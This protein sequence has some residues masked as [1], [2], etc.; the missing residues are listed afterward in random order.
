MIT[1]LVLTMTVLLLQGGLYVY[2]MRRDR[3]HITQA[4]LLLLGAIPIVGILVLG[5]QVL[6]E[7]GWITRKPGPQPGPPTARTVGRVSERTDLDREALV[8]D[9]R[10]DPIDPDTLEL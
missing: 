10:L 3:S 1:L 6:Y 9:Y 8:D 5:E 7:A 2:V 4:G